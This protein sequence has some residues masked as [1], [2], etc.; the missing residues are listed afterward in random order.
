MLF[1]GMRCDW[2]KQLDVHADAL[3]RDALCM[4]TVGRHFPSHK[5]LLPLGDRA[6]VSPNIWFLELDRVTIPNGISIGF[7]VFAGLTNR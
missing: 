1:L 7:A 3:L 5:M 4:L 6:P 2:L